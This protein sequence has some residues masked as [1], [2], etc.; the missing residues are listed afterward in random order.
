MLQALNSEALMQSDSCTAEKFDRTMRSPCVGD[1]V[2]IQ[3]LDEQVSGLDSDASE[4]FEEEPQR[5]E[6]ISDES[7]FGDTEIEKLVLREGP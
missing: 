3:Q 7:E 1:H 4:H 5:L 6:P 2:E